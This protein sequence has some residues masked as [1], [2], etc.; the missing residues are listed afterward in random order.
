M[1]TVLVAALNGTLCDPARGW[2]AGFRKPV[3]PVKVDFKVLRTIS[4][5][6]ALL[7]PFSSATTPCIGWPDGS[8][9]KNYPQ[10]KDIPG[11]YGEERGAWA[12]GGDP[13][14]LGRFSG[15]SRDAGLKRPGPDPNRTPQ[16]SV[17]KMSV[18]AFA[19]KAR[20]AA[21][22]R[23]RGESV[24]MAYK[25]P[26]KLGLTSPPQSWGLQAPQS[27]GLQAPDK[28]GLSPGARGTPKTLGL[29]QRVE[30]DAAPHAAV[31]GV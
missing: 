25:P 18:S 24:A 1:F 29:A 10:I 15:G 11:G 3:A 26:T 9:F 27:W 28:V 31:K 23:G 8:R 22:S 2:Q 20:T 14:R 5:N 12:G 4:F 21:K 7:S 17:S 19:A 6:S 13:R 16:S 30:P